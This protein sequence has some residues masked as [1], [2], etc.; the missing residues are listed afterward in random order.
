MDNKRNI[1]GLVIVVSLSMVWLQVIWPWMA[2]RNNWSLGPTTK[3]A[4]VSTPA[5]GPAAATTS[6]AATTNPAAAAG[7]HAAVP[8]TQ[9]AAPVIL[10]NTAYDPKQ[11]NTYPI[12]LTISPRGAGLDAVTLNRFKQEYDRPDPY[13][14]Q[15]PYEVLSPM[16]QS[17]ATRSVT[18]DGGPPISLDSLDWQPASPTTAPASPAS[19]AF[20]TEVR[21][22]TSPVLRITK[23]FE[24]RPATDQTAGYEVLV[25]YSVANLSAQPHVVRVAFNGPNAPRPENNRDVPEVVAGF[26]GGRVNVDLHHHATGSIKAEEPLD[27]K[28]IASSEKLL[29]SGM[30][31][32]YFD[33]IVRATDSAGNP[34]PLAEVKALTLTPGEKDPLKQAVAI[35]YQTGDLAVPADGV[36][37]FALNTYFGP[38]AREVLN[39]KYYAAFPRSYDDTLILTSSCYSFCTWS[40]LINLLVLLLQGFHIVFRDW[41]LAIIGLVLLVRLILHPVTKSSQVSMSRMTK[42]GPEMERLK[43]KYGE[44]TEGLKKAQ[45]E[46]Y[47]EQG[48]AP[49]LGCLPMFL[50]MPIWI[51]LW[52]ALQSTFEIRHAPFLQ[53]GGH[54]LTWIH[55][56][57]QPDRLLAFKQ[58]LN[59]LFFHIDGLNLLP[60]L[61]G[62]VFFINQKL[63]P[64]P[65]A[66]N[67]DQQSQQKMMQWMSVLLFPIFL[68]SSPSGLNLYIFTSTLIGIFE[69]KRI[70]AH[71]KE[72]EEREKAGVVIID[73]PDTRRANGAQA[74]APAKRGGI[75]GGIA[76]FMAKMQQMA[77]EA[78]KEQERQQKKKR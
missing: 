7:L 63:Q 1:I 40:W 64:Q 76:G 34:L 27:V 9:P 11:S 5:G 55:D 19:A 70:R 18:I 4:A 24:V 51:A 29:W 50:Q 17:M 32:A 49:F 37:T 74:A 36:T 13:V 57:A 71:I 38:K 30:T 69:S 52:S 2:K 56:L 68:Y 15:K 78:K 14:F 72:K 66:M 20:S 65:V 25:H 47:R 16:S 28:A 59:L 23:S 77:E 54:S 75:A 45:V 31:S 8:S 6:A 60:I 12:G 3:P 33:A 39:N 61:M 46:F 41:G 42:L 73:A 44:D 53:F 62:I 21:D 58:P 10:G 22:G 43:K 67:P 48:I 26:D 35:D